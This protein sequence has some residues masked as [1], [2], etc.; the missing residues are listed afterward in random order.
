MLHILPMVPQN[1]TTFNCCFLL[2][3][4]FLLIHHLSRLPSPQSSGVTQKEAM[5]INKSLSFL[6]QVQYRTPSYNSHTLTL[7]ILTR[8][9]PA[10]FIL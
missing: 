6:E 3:P 9:L 8:L 5:Y 4:P 10:C 7:S 2:P 1:Y